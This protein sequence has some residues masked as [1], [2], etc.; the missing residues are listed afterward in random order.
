M[1]N[2]G[3]SS[4]KLALF[5]EE[6]PVNQIQANSVSNRISSLFDSNLIIEDSKLILAGY[7]PL[8]MPF[9]PHIVILAYTFLYVFASQVQQSI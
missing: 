9:P 6:I 2:K 5:I 4:F 7:H 3:D 8:A 1:S